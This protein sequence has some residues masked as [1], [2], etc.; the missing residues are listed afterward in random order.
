MRPGGVPARSGQAHL[1]HVGGCGDRAH[2]HTEATDLEL[3]L[4]VQPEDG[5]NAVEAAVGDDVEPSAGHRLLGRLEH[6]SHPTPL[7]VV[8]DVREREPAPEHDRRVHVVAAGVGDA[9]TLRPVRDLLLVGHRERVDVGPQRDPGTVIRSRDVAHQPGADGESSG[10]E[11][12]DLQP[13]CDERG[14]VVLRVAELG[15]GVQLT[16]ERDQ[17]LEVAVEEL[18]DGCV[19]VGHGRAP[20]QSVASSSASA[21]TTSTRVPPLSTMRRCRT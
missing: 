8:E 20:G 2:A 13:L 7:A 16:A 1:D 3:G 12:G 17:L 15:M 9:G 21:A 18:V 19:D 4:A 11:T 10:R 5:G 14:G 6:Q